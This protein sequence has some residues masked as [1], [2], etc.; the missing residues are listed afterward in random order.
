M[1]SAELASRQSV[2]RDGQARC[3]GGKV[4]ARVAKNDWTVAFGPNSRLFR[5]VE[6]SPRLESLLEWS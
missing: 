4:C 6:R 1:S 5:V 2:R 3:A